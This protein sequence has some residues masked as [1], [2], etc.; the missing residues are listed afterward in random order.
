MID[1]MISCIEYCKSLGVP[2]SAN[3]TDVGRADPEYFIDMVNAAVDAGVTEVRLTD[4]YSSLSPEGTRHL[5]RM[6]VKNLKRPVPLY[7]VYITAWATEDG[8]IQFRRDLYNK[9]GVGPTA[10]AY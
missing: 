2:V 10:S 3:Y 1:K 8:V 5:I 4:S 6:L 9:D 7:F